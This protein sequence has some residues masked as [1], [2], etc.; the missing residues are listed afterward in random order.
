[1]AAGEIFFIGYQVDKQPPGVHYGG[2]DKD[3][4][5]EFD[6]KVEL[7]EVRTV[8]EPELEVLSCCHRQCAVQH[9]CPVD[10]QSIS[11]A[12]R[13]MQGSMKLKFRCAARLCSAS[14]RQQPHAVYIHCTGDR[15]FKVRENI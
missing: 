8:F 9:L 15:D 1:M 5:L 11:S 14:R 6:V 12:A 10:P 2:A 7:K 3:G 4:K 13:I